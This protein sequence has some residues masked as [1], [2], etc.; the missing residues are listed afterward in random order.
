MGSNAEFQKEWLIGWAL[1]GA[2]KLEEAKLAFERAHHLGVFSTKNHF[3]AHYAKWRIALLEKK[4][5]H[6]ILQLFLML[7]RVLTIFLRKCN[8][9][10]IPISHKAC[11]V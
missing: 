2:N 11:R 6:V 8:I 9:S 7:I 10:K 5:S 4:T 1:L 3:L